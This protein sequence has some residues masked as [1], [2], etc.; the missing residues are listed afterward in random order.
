[1]SARF[2]RTSLEVGEVMF[3]IADIPSS[4]GSVTLPSGPHKSELFGL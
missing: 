4:M 2:V 3:E 1:M